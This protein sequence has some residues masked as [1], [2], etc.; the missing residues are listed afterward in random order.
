MTS[1][2][3]TMVS[4]TGYSNMGYSNTGYA[5]TG[6]NTS[7]YPNGAMGTTNMGY[8]GYTGG[9][10]NNMGYSTAGYGNM[11]YNTMGTGLMLNPAGNPN[12]LINPM[13]YMQTL[14][15]YL[16]GVAPSYQNLTQA[17]MPMN[18]QSCIPMTGSVYPSQPYA[19]NNTNGSIMNYGS[20]NTPVNN[21]NS[22]GAGTIQPYR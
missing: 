11:G 8:S 16:G 15:P 5:N 20:Y 7:M 10:M 9:A 1:Y 3:N 13:A 22:I 6:Y 2:G 18:S 4:N 17:Y 19:I 12:M 21:Y 14:Q